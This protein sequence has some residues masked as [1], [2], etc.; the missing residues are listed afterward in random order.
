MGSEGA[1]LNFSNWGR[2][3]QTQGILAPGADIFGARVGGGIERRSGTSFATALVSGVAAL[4]LSLQ[5]KRGGRVDPLAVRDAIIESAIGCED[6]PISDCRR[7]LAGR[8][9][10][11]GAVS[12]LKKG[13]LIMPDESVKP[14]DLPCIPGGNGEGGDAA[15]TS[16]EATAAVHAAA[17]DVVSEMGN[18]DV[19]APEPTPPVI[20]SV[21]PADTAEPP[22]AEAL[23]PFR[24]LTPSECTPSGGGIGAAQASQLVYALG[25]L[26]YDFGTEAHS[27]R[28]CSATSRI[29]WTTPNSWHTCSMTPGT[30]PR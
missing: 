19:P 8:L 21:N 13:A 15:E 5:L 26:G 12:T 18:G 25:E 10:L 16:P 2:A 11:V 22:R 1:P 23:A 29:P 30:P 28:S 20:R 14:K 17:A 27:I 4:L 6:Q 3:Y 7:L 9:N 24:H